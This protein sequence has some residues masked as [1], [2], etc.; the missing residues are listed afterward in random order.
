M[1]E[2]ARPMSNEVRYFI[3]NLGNHNEL[4]IKSIEHENSFALGFYDEIH[5]NFFR[6]HFDNLY[7]TVQNGTADENL[8]GETVLDKDCLQFISRIYYGVKDAD[9]PYQEEHIPGQ[10]IHW[11]IFDPQEQL[12]LVAA[13]FFKLHEAYTEAW[14]F[15]NKE[16]YERFYHSAG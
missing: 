4:R 9:A 7:E 16:G 1:I 6:V 5:L 8:F 2:K 3:R 11:I 13:A 15:D 12:Y 14:E 10:N